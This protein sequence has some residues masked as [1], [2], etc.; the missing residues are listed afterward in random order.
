MHAHQLSALQ[1]MLPRIRGEDP[2][3]KITRDN[4]TA[5]IG[6]LQHFLKMKASPDPMLSDAANLMRL[7]AEKARLR[8]R[9]AE[10][11][12]RS[13]SAIDQLRARGAAAQ[14]ADELDAVRS[15]SA[16]VVASVTNR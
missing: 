4:I 14:L 7:D 15:A 2:A 8:Q 11:D 6:D 10:L 16:Q 5:H 12:A 3:S 1:A 9:S 13:A